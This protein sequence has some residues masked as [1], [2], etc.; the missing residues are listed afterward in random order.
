ME[1]VAHTLVYDSVISQA[2]SRRLLASVTV[3][4][5]VVSSGSSGDELTAM[6]TAV[7]AAMPDACHRSVPGTW[8][9]ADDDVLADALVGFFRTPPSRE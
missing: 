9:G 2:T 7:A 3:P 1:A 6:S 5:L 8:H 4:T